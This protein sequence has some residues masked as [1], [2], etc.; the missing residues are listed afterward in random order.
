MSF[1]RIE[2]LTHTYAPRESAP[3]QALNG[4]DLEI[5]AGEYVAIIGANGSG[6]TTLARH[7][8]ALLY[9]TTGDVWIDGRNTCDL[10]AVRAIRAQVGMVFQSPADQIVATVVQED[11]A[12]GPENLGVREEELPARVRAALQQVSMWGSRHRPPHLLSSGEQQRVAIAG[13][14]AMNPRCL[15]LD[16]ATAMLDPIGRRDV[17]Q[18][19]DGLHRA[20]LTILTITH[21]ME[22]ALRAQRVI[23]LH[24]GR[25]AL[26]GPSGHVF[27]SPA[28]ALYGLALPPAIELAHRLREHFPS[29]PDRL[30]TAD[31]LADAIAEVVA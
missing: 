3:I 8:N 10:S 29:L 1:I 6:K 15:V 4:I 21:N 2:R 16:E 26:D 31:A 19:V 24:A 30:F 14:L 9:P 22:E 11:V 12:F 17:L 23:V 7:L 28:L 27:S 25:I 18:I 13:V 5:D 20:G